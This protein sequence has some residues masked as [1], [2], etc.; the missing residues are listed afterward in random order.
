[1]IP[2]IPAPILTASDSYDILEDDTN[3]EEIFELF[4]E[5]VEI[6]T[7][8]DDIGLVLLS[9]SFLTDEIMDN[10]N[11]GR[12]TTVLIT[13]ELRKIAGSEP[14]AI[15]DFLHFAFNSV[16]EM[17]W[18]KAY[19]FAVLVSIWDIHKQ[20]ERFPVLDKSQ[21]QTF[22]KFKNEHM[23]EIISTKLSFSNRV[24]N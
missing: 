22:Q 14:K 12:R 21:T 3:D 20:S 5:E 2:D 17:S 11:L 18:P 23:T 10:E 15:S 6:L 16:F 1:M 4:D 9:E 24:L 8:D 13:E 19:Q 7:V